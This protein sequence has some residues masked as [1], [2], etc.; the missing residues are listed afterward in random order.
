MRNC[1]FFYISKEEYE[2]SFTYELVKLRKLK[3]LIPVPEDTTI[4]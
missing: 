2:T 1:Y 4:F 3:G